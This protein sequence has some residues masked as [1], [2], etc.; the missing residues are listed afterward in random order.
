MTQK[1]R[2][3]RLVSEFDMQEEHAFSLYAGGAEPVSCYSTDNLQ[4][5]EDIHGRLVPHML[6]D[7]FEPLE[8][9]FVE[10]EPGGWKNPFGLVFWTR[11]AWLCRSERALVTRYLS[12]LTVSIFSSVENLDREVR[13]MQ[14]DLEK[15]QH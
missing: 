2:V 12:S 13:A 1:Q 9:Y 3:A 8:W 14:D 10:E 4:S 7:E 5:W 6:S 11:G 15:R